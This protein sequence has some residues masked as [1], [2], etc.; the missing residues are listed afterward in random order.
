M[1]ISDWSSDVC[2]SDLGE[3]DVVD[4]PGTDEGRP[5]NA[6]AR[7]LDHHGGGIAAGGGEAVAAR[8]ELQLPHIARMGRLNWL[9]EGCGRRQRPAEDAAIAV[10][11]DQA[12]SVR[13]KGDGAEVTDTVDQRPRADPVRSGPHAR[14]RAR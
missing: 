6:A 8:A 2:S 14:H 9:E 3:G 4:A 11:G 1:R 7:I 5:D 13:R 10:A 12:A